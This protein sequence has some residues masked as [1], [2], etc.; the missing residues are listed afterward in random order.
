M[1]LLTWQRVKIGF[2]INPFSL[3][4]NGLLQILKMI[5]NIKENVYAPIFVANYDY[6]KQLK[7]HHI[8]S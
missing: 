6:L 4:N 3:L 2:G 5:Q 1:A 7:P 8:Y